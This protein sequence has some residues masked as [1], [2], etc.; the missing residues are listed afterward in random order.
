[1]QDLVGNTIENPGANNPAAFRT[2]ARSP[3]NGLL[4]EAFNSGPD[5]AVATLVNS[6]VFPDH[7]FFRTNLWGFDSRIAF[8]DNTH[9][10]YGSRIRGVFIPPVS[11]DWVFYLRS[12]DRAEVY[13]N[14]NGLEAAGK[15]LLVA[16]TTGNDPRDY[17]KLISSPVSLRG[18]QAYYLEGLQQANAGTDYIK[19]VARLAG[20]GLPPLG[21][22]DTDIDPNT[23]LGGAVGFPLAPR[24]LGGA[25]I[26]VQDV[27]DLSV[28]ENHPVTLSVQVSNPSGLPISYQWRRGGVDIPGANGPTYSLV[29]TL[30]DN[31]AV[32]SVQAAKIGAVLTSRDATLTVNADTTPPVV[33]GVH[34]SY[35]LNEVLVS[36]SELMR[37]DPANSIPDTANF[38]IDDGSAF[39]VQGAVVDATGTNILLTL[40]LPLAPGGV[41]SLQIDATID[42]AGNPNDSTNVPLQAFVLSQGFLRFDYFGGLST[43]DNNLASTLLVDPRY[44]NTPDQRYFMSAFDSRTVFPGDTRE[45]YGARVI[46]LFTPA[47]SG[48]Y[49]F[50]LRSDDSSRLYLNPTGPDPAGV[51]LIAEET[52][53]CN[54]FSTNASAPQALTA[55]PS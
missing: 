30:A 10:A 29:P 28:E 14:P 43:T 33:A 40:D 7:P 5:V 3:G 49:I 52:A 1:V 13:L 27:A 47:V 54:P 12:I 23:I 19:V 15:Q 20:T 17:Q 18:G 37:S 32:F 4:F 8:P 25:L 2:W 38:R 44:P 41:Y 16:E 34:G 9:E 48:D 39:S 55:G 31:G 36:F 26:L 21:L 46:G 53:C 22:P 51:V 6:P 24:D 45:G 35:L 11:G 50:Y 42:V